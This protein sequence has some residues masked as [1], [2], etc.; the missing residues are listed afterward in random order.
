MFPDAEKFKPERFFAEN[1]IN[2]HPQA[3]VAFSAGRL[4]CK[5]Q[6][7]VLMELKVIL[8]KLLKKRETRL[9]SYLKISIDYFS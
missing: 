7:L 9:K 6:R 8:A 4:N 2:I 1:S 3:N 5:G